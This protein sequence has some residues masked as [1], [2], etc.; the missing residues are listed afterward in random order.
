L[1]EGD[2]RF[3]VCFGWAVV[4]FVLDE[5]GVDELVG[6]GATDGVVEAWTG[7]AGCWLDVGESC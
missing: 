2:G 4:E 7:E 5:A 1:G 6:A 3:V